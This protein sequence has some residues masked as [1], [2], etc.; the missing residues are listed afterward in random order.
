MGSVLAHEFEHIYDDYA[1]RIY[2]LDSELRGFKTNVL[3]TRV[4]RYAS[5]E[6]YKRLTETNDD[7]TRRQMKDFMKSKR[8]TTRG[9]SPSSRKSP[10]ATATSIVPKATSPR[11]ASL[12]ARRSAQDFSACPTRSPRPRPCATA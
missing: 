4:L 3:Y 11:R 1:G 10:T 5:P 9:P 6:N 12:C 2:T 8:P 7:N